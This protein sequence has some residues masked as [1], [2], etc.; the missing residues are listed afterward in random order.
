MNN[1]VFCFSRKV[2]RC[3]GNTINVTLSVEKKKTEKNLTHDN[4][5]R[6][7]FKGKKLSEEHKMWHYRRRVK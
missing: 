2:T 7:R 5:E 6:N 1:H 3:F 4:V